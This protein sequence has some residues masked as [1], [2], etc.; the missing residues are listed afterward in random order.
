VLDILTTPASSS[1][2]TAYDLVM[3]KQYAS[4]MPQAIAVATMACATLREP[5]GRLQAIPGVGR[6]VGL[7]C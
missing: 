2:E 4:I 1:P 6:V 5:L 3:T 7:T